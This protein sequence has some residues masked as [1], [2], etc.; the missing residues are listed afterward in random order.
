MIYGLIISQVMRSID[1]LSMAP[2]SQKGEKHSSWNSAIFT[3]PKSAQNSRG[4]EYEYLR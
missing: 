2:M 4:H 1:R 3:K